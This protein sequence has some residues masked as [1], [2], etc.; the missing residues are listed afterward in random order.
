MSA[1]AS[2][3]EVDKMSFEE[4]LAELEEIVRRLEKGEGQLEGAIGAYE[5]GANLKRHCERKLVEAKAKVDRITLGPDGSPG[6][7]PSEIG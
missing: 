5:R 7:E 1:K 4:A 3:A 6:V 2:P